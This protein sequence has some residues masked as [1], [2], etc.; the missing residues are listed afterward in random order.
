M[1]IERKNTEENYDYENDFDIEEY[2]N[3]QDKDEGSLTS[4]A[5][6]KRPQTTLFR[7]RWS[8]GQQEQELLA[9]VKGQ[10]AKYS[11]RVYAKSFNLSDYWDLYGA[12]CEMWS[13]FKEIIGQ[14][15]NDEMDDLQ[16]HIE[17]M[18]ETCEENDGIVSKDLRISLLEF[19][20]KVYMLKQRSNLG[21][22]VERAGKSST[23]GAIRDISE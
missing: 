22:E 7:S 19:K 9:F 16:K 4:L 15:I 12:T 5:E 18:L 1:K 23:A 17:D 20:Q 13:L 11:I 2:D 10:V 14:T 21:L 8:M 3:E 6:I